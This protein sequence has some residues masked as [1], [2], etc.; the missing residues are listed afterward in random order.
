MIKPT[1]E[2]PLVTINILSY[3]R[4]DEVDYTLNKLNSYSE[5]PKDKIEIIV[6]DNNS[7][8]GTVEM[9]KKKYPY[10]KVIKSKKNFGVSSWNFGFN[11]G[12]GKYFLCLDDDSHPESNLK[13]NILFMEKHKDIGIL[14]AKILMINGRT[15]YKHDENIFIGCGVIIRSELIK[16]IGGYS[17]WIFLYS[18][19]WEF[20]IRC[21]N[22]D[23]KI[24]KSKDF[25]VNHRISKTTRISDNFQIYGVRNFLGI[26]YAYF[27]GLTK[28]ILMIITIIRHLFATS[29]FRKNLALVT[30]GIKKFFS[31]KSHIEKQRIKKD[32]LKM[33]RRYAASHVVKKLLR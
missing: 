19:E 33:Y 32:V 27:N 21:L 10:V 12:N 22:S 20:S 11:Q 14:A 24:Y 4:K 29:N 3:N 1:Q 18:H 17:H 13:K 2:L 5:Y 28:Y 7:I 26:V 30:K 23:Y 15:E 16:K 6:V 25:I 8:D 31:I 9:I